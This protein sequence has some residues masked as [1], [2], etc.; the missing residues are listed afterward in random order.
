MMNIVNTPSPFPSHYPRGRQEKATAVAMYIPRS[1]YNKFKSVHTNE[2]FYFV[3]ILAKRML[4]RKVKDHEFQSLK[5]EYLSRQLGSM[6]RER[7]IQ[8]LIDDGVV[9]VQS[10]RS[11][12]ESYQVRSRSKAYR[13]KEVYRNEVIQDILIGFWA[14]KGT[15]LSRRL[16]RNRMRMSEASLKTCP[17]LIREFQWIQGLLFDEA[18][19]NSYRDQFESTGLRGSAVYNRYS[20]IRLEY[21]KHAL[22][23]L[24]QGDFYFKY[25]G[26]R[27]TTAITSAMRELRTCLIDGRGNYFIELDLRSSQLVFICKALQVC[28]DNGIVEN[29][30]NELMSFV[31][32]DID[33]YSSAVNRYDD[34]GAFIRQVTNDDIYREIYHLQFLH[35]EDWI[36]I[37]EQESVKSAST[38]ADPR[39]T[40]RRSD[41]KKTVLKDILFNYYT[42]KLNIPK[43]A[44]AFAE[45]YPQLD[46]LLRGMASESTKR[47][48]SADLAQVTQSYEAHFFH[49]VGLDALVRAYPDREFYIVHDSVGVPEDIA[50][51]CQQI[52]NEALE[53]HLGIP[54]VLKLISA[55]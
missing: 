23:N 25:N 35:Q 37:N 19:A 22:G 51:E 40:S 24:T 39:F 1:Y 42:R 6:P 18:K 53:R 44:K 28:S 14:E 29:Y 8:R 34:I 3:H 27:L 49:G 15:A 31:I 36:Q 12:G 55:D 47:K 2:Q 10:S 52:L 54:A 46:H 21:D 33:I 41:F 13:L 11:S 9:E 7:Q 48:K 45:A 26:T 38:K 43:F 17:M 4:E 20:A 5:I 32:D 16:K 50:E 30:F